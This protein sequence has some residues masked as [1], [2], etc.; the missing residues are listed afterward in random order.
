M[1]QFRDFTGRCARA[2][3][4]AIV[5]APRRQAALGALVVSL[6]VVLPGCM[7]QRRPIEVIRESGDNHYR[8][9]DYAGARDEY[10]EITSTYPGDWE[11]QYRLG[12]SMIETQQYDGARQALEQ[13]YTLKP[14]QE[15]A[16]ALAKAMFL[17]KDENRL[18]AFL[19]ER[20]SST[21]SVPAY[22]QLANYAMEMN[23]PDSARV[24]VDTAIEV[25]MGKS[26]EPYIAAAQL[27]Q[28]L[29]HTDVAIQR[30]R[31]AYGI[32]E[33]DRRVHD[34]LR[35]LGQDPFRLKPIR[36]GREIIEA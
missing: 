27:E 12:L 13:A 23:D 32:N 8:G 14:T 3:A 15:V 17:Q 9:G 18:F 34:L 11:A 1:P 31:Q 4:S 20:A 36:P 29:G 22:L 30:L 21:R 7:S 35:Q 16:D 2:M 33:Y 26:T 19:R 24:A 25:D 6:V 5:I 10:A 28:R